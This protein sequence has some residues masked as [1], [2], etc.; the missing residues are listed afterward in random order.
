MRSGGSIQPTSTDCR[1]AAFRLIL[2][3]TTVRGGR[4]TGRVESACKVGDFDAIVPS[5]EGWARIYGHN[6]ITVD[7]QDDPYWQG[8]V[9]T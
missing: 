9:V 4:S 2:A 5:L 6:F 1:M 7:P 3:S 8:F